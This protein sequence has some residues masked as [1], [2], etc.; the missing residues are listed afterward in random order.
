MGSINRFI[1]TLTAASHVVT[2]D[3]A[4]GA[5]THRILR[6]AG[7]TNT[8]VVNERPPAQ[9]RIFA[10]TNDQVA[11]VGGIME[12]LKAGK[13]VVVVS[14]SAEKVLSLLETAKEY[15]A[16]ERILCHTAKTA[17]KVKGRRRTMGEVPSRHVHPVRRRRRGLQHMY[18]YMCGMSVPPATALQI[19][20]RVRH[21]GDTTVRCCAAPNMRLIGGCPPVSSTQMTEWL[22][23]MALRTDNADLVPVL[24]RIGGKV[25]DVLLPQ[26]SYWSAIMAFVE[27]ES[28]NTNANFMRMYRQKIPY[29]TIH[30]HT[31]LFSVF[32][33]P[34]HI[35]LA[36]GS[37]HNTYRLLWCVRA[38]LAHPHSPIMLY[39]TPQHPET[40]LGGGVG[41]GT[42][43][44]CVQLGA[45]GTTLHWGC[46]SKRLRVTGWQS[47][48]ALSRCSY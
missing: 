17:N 6:T 1:H 48:K 47:S 8:L 7:L 22:R 41:R 46:L 5:A 45:Q 36:P 43:N 34:G 39:P 24:A 26:D 21:L 33:A 15:I 9:P 38:P 4:W 3:A 40:L 30:P 19:L 20:F 31:W 10:V 16:A 32:H 37:R 18:F 27:A 42:Y 29:R 11:C 44:W 28:Y 23:W 14:L 35:C 13:K 25:K 2:L 12:D